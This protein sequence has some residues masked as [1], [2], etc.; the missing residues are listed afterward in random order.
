MC[1]RETSNNQKIMQIPSDSAL[2]GTFRALPPGLLLVLGGN[3]MAAEPP[4]G[5]DPPDDRPRWE[6]SAGIGLTISA[7][8][9]EN[10]LFSANL[11]T[12][13]KWEQNEL[14]FGVSGGYGESRVDVIDPVTGEITRRTDKNTDFVRGFG[15]YNRLFTERFYG[16]ARADAVHDDIANVV[17]RVALSPGAGYYFIKDSRTTLSGELGPG[18]VFERTYNQ[19]DNTYETDNYASIRLSERFEHRLSDR[20][21]VWQFAEV[22]P[23]VDD[24]E[25]FIIN[26][27]VGVEADLTPKLSLRVVAQDTYDNQPAVGRKHNDFKLIAGLN[28]RF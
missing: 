2:K 22:L 16:Y 23:Q 7:G 21:R 5:G 27:E 18:Y 12:Q 10:L 26:A 8:N 15:Q 1:S 3:L 14:Q 19:Q 17:Y 9:T 24:F 28:Y 4:L 13:R 6:T 11:G 20:A 25:N